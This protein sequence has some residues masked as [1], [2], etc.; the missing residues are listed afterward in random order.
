M[1]EAGEREAL[2]QRLGRTWRTDGKVRT[3]ASTA[4]GMDW[5]YSLAQTV[6]E[7]DQ[8]AITTAVATIDALDASD[9]ERA[10]GALDDVLLEFA[11]REVRMAAIRLAA[12][13]E[14][15]SS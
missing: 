15:W 6:L 11:P 3:Y 2:A 12:R 10:H 8:S 14:R 1:V 13:S 9:P 4:V 5:L 7:A